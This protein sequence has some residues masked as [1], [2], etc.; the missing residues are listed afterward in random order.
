MNLSRSVN[1]VLEVEGDRRRILPSRARA[2]GL[3]VVVSQDGTGPVSWSV[4]YALARAE[5]LVEGAWAPRTLDQLHTLNLRGAYRF[6]ASWQLSGTW[7]YHTGWP[8][9]EQLLDVEV[10]LNESGSEQVDVIRRGLG[11]YNAG[12][13]PPYHRFDVR[14]TRTFDLSRSRLDVYLDVFN[15]YNPYEPAWLPQAPARLRRPLHGIPLDRRGAASD[16]AHA[17]TPLGVLK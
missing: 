3:E 16:P 8:F 17:R 14:V 7:S 2:K 11:D 1:P 12:R 4:S 15:A 6:G 13:L 10:G 5:D 9:T